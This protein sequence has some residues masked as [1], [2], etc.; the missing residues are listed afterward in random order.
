[1]LGTFKNVI[2]DFREKGLVIVIKHTISFI[3]NNYFERFYG[4]HTTGHLSSNALGYASK[5]AHEYIATDVYSFRKIMKSINI[6]ENDVFLDYGSGMGRVLIMAALFPFRRVVG[7][8]LSPDLNAI[9]I[10]N[11][12]TVRKRLRCKSI[13][14]IGADAATYRVTPDI[15]V[16]YCYNSFSGEIL[17]RVLSNIHESVSS[18]PRNL[19]IIYKNPPYFEEQVKSMCWLKKAF[20]YKPFYGHKYIVYTVG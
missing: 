15:T 12:E 2:R 17:A 6:G 16:I 4:I 14:V 13:E 20:E 5:Y 19:T 1:M 10:K 8:D 3:Y 7:I 11:I 9:A 18:V